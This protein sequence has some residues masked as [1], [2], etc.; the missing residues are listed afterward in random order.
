VSIGRESWIGIGAN[1]KHRVNI[2]RNVVVGC[3]AAVVSHIDS[4]C[5]VVGIPAKPVKQKIS[6]PALKRI[7]TA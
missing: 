1:V 6:Q 4:N 3:G 2:G 5:T 7:T